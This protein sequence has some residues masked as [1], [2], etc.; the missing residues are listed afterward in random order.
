[1]QL[2]NSSFKKQKQKSVSL[3]DITGS[4]MKSYNHSMSCKRNRGYQ[5]MLLL[6]KLM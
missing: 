2:I 3:M 1:M 4:V 5:G 6:V